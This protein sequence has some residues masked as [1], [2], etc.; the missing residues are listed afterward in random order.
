MNDMD[1][2]VEWQED[3]GVMGGAPPKCGFWIAE[4]GFES[5]RKETANFKLR[6]SALWLRTGSLCETDGQ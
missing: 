5:G 6:S 1:M 2:Q 4:C 3:G